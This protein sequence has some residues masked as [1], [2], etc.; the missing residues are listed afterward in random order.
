MDRETR[1]LTLREALTFAVKLHRQ[2]QLDEAEAIYEALFERSPDHPDLL[3]FYGLL[4]H[5]RRHS[6]RALELIGRSIELAPDHPDVHANL[7]NV[8]RDLDQLDGAAAAY[9]RALELTP[10]NVW[11]MNNLASLLGKRG[12]YK[13]AEA[14]FQEV[15][16]R[17]PDH[18]LGFINLGALLLNQDRVAEAEQSFRKALERDPD[19]MTAKF[20]LGVAEFRSQTA[21][22]IAAD[23]ERK[24]QR[25]PSNA[26][27]LHLLAASRGGDVPER[28]SDAY[29]TALFDGYAERF[30]DQIAALGYRAPQLVG[31][32]VRRLY[33][34]EKQLDILDAGC[35]TGL[36]GPRL[37]PYGKRLVGVDL[38]LGM[39]AKARQRSVYDSLIVDELTRFL[40]GTDER[41]DLVV[42]VDT[43]CYFG[44][45]EDVLRGSA[46]VLRPGGRLIFTL[47]KEGGEPEAG[48]RL[49]LTGRYTHAERY[50]R[51]AL[52][53]A[54]LDLEMLEEARLRY[55]ALVPVIGMVLCARRPG[56]PSAP[57]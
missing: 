28:A 49:D 29:V 33:Q 31:A 4:L 21:E 50:V 2:G 9:R 35:G 17:L 34:T 18:C 15:I 46:R 25:D 11:V 14:L 52:A 30:D 3:H 12:E 55:Q 39:I 57:P 26:S 10:E 54:D 13:E 41:F 40:D 20:A 42:S 56:E 43:F 5:Q 1:R 24:L 51:Q 16:E 19:N 22:E 48:H 27:A 37:T 38:S 53:E 7:G 36:C 44:P 23:A 45:L 32:V 47:E 8:L 6:D